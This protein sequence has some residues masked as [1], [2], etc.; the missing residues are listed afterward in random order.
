VSESGESVRIVDWL[1]SRTPEPPATVS[2]SLGVI[3]GSESCDLQD[4][5]SRLLSH[6]MVILKKPRDDRSY[7]S[8]LLA[9][10]ALITYAVEAAAETCQDFQVF[11]E[12]AA[13]QLSSPGE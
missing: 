11:A 1:A 7:A 2:A 3:V 5:P 10:D 8:E 9:A 6:A 12:T 4:L 13:A